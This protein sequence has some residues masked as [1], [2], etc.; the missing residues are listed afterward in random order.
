MEIK[1]LKK[2]NR[3]ELLELLLEQ[4]RRNDELERQLNERAIALEKAGNIAEA[5]LALHKVFES[6]Q[7]AA[8]TYVESVRALYPDANTI[9]E[10]IFIE[11]DL[12][13][14]EGQEG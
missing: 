7:A 10:D 12:F 13:E 11:E 6:A 1:D 2:L 4:T 14:D 9:M 3:E 8:D 5:A